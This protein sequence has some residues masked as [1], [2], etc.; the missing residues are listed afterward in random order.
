MKLEGT[1]AVCLSVYFVTVTALCFSRRSFHGLLHSLLLNGS[2]P[3]GVFQTIAEQMLK[4]NNEK[5]C[6]EEMISI[7][8]EIEA[9]LDSDSQ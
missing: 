5:E 9:P 2:L 4:L 3:F 1:G 6:T 8:S 7:I